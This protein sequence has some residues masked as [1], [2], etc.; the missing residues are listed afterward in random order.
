MEHVF[1]TVYFHS[2]GTCTVQHK[3]SIYSVPKQNEAVN[4][5]LTHGEGFMAQ[6]IVQKTESMTRLENLQSKGTR[7][8]KT[9]GKRKNVL[10]KI[11]GSTMGY[12]NWIVNALTVFQ[13]LLSLILPKLFL[14][15]NFYSLSVPLKEIMIFL[16]I[17]MRD[18][19]EKL[20]PL[21][22]SQYWFTQNKRYSSS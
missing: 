8:A 10:E 21:H 7:W 5:D 11:Q 17:R 14:L 13:I 12:W 22:L 16:A 18:F 19:A 15:H 2:S 6:G 3:S 4:C 9:R 1:A 20:S